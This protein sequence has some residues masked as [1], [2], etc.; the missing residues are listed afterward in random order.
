MTDKNSADVYLTDLSP[1]TLERVANGDAGPETS[2][3][4]LH[5]HVFL[6]PEAGKTPIERTA[7]SATA[8]LVVLARGHAGVYD[9]AG[10]LMPGRS[11]RKGRASGTLRH[12][13]TRL[14]RRTAGFEDLLGASTMRV[15][16][17]SRADE[18]TSDLIAR[19]MR[20]AVAGTDPVE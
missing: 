11:L 12:A 10:F 20:V 6:S 2:G 14:T 17:G 9:G 8:R 4:I 18:P 13:P 16:F 1:D 15:T 3:T 7:A 5:V 19:A